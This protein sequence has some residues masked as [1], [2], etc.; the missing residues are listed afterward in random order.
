MLASPVNF[1]E[2]RSIG[3][4]WTLEVVVTDVVVGRILRGSDDVYRYYK[5]HG[6]DG[7]A[8]PVPPQADA[9]DADLE[10][11]KAWIQDH[12]PAPGGVGV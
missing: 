2:T 11:L 12:V 7:V 8:N 4:D 6:P 10:R 3:H 1:R 5:G 9:E